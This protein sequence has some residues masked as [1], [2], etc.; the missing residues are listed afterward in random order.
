MY[1]PPAVFYIPDINQYG[2]AWGTG[3]RQNL[4]A[5]DSTTGQLYVL[6]DNN[7]EPTTSGLPLT[8]AKLTSVSPSATYTVPPTTNY[9]DTAPSGFD[10]GWYFNLAAGERVLTEPFALGGL[11]VFN[12]YVPIIATGGTGS[13]KT[14]QDSGTSYLYTVNIT[15]GSGLVETT[16]GSGSSTTITYS[17]NV[18]EPQNLYLNIS[19][20]DAV[21]VI[22][23]SNGSG[24][25]SSSGSGSVGS[26]S[27]DP[28]SAAFQAEMSQLMKLMPT[29]CRF[30]NKTVNV[31]ISG[32]FGQSTCA[33]GVP[34]CIV[35]KNWKEF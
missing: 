13:T 15:N 34:V 27:C 16:S 17:T 31:N 30:S 8:T 9:L 29:S 23:S 20:S 25:G 19:V 12:T 14:C 5:P 7:F 26:A 28:T 33:A 24:G 3:N 2:I 1:Y 4:W 22:P 11:L 32:T 6:V 21:P 18:S 10:A 35:E